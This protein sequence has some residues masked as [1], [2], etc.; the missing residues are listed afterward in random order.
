MPYATLTGLPTGVLLRLA[1]AIVLYLLLHL[2]RL[3]LLLAAAVL[4]VSMH[5]M[6]AYAAH[7][8]GSESAPAVLP[9][10]PHRTRGGA[11]CH[12]P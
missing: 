10:C 12:A 11:R 5:R 3:P 1:A 2:V 8:T 7:L 9:A 4:A 6:A